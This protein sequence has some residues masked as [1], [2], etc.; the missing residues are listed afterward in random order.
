MNLGTRRTTVGNVHV[1]VVEGDID[2]QVDLLQLI[3]KLKIE[4][5]D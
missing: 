2:R 1:L 3:G 4:V 5:L